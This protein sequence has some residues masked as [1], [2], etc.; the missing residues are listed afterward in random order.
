MVCVSRDI[1]VTHYLF[2]EMQQYRRSRRSVVSCVEPYGQG[3]HTVRTWWHGSVSVWC[4]VR[5]AV[6]GGV[7]PD[8]GGGSVALWEG[9]KCWD[10]EVGA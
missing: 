6:E 8:D 4:F 5:M 3:V 2:N 1:H 10:G 9:G 7:V